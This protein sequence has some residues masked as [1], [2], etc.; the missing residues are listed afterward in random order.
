[1]DDF[2][3]VDTWERMDDYNVWEER[4]LDLDR[5]AG[6]YDEPELTITYDEALAK[7]LAIFPHA[8]FGDDN[9]GQLIIYTDMVL[10]G[11]SVRPFDSTEDD[12]ESE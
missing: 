2:D 5:A 7:V 9:D 10:D 11:I 8:T 4:Q 12:D 1:M 6:E 3:T